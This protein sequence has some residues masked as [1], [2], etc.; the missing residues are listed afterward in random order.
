MRSPPLLFPL[1]T[2]VTLV[3]LALVPG[4]T[5]QASP[6]ARTQLLEVPAADDS[7]GP[8][9]SAGGGRL[10][11]SWIEPSGERHR[12]R[13]AELG[14]AAWSRPRDVAEGTDWFV[15]WADFPSV[16]PIADSLWAAH[17]LVSQPAGGYAY[18]VHLSFSTDAGDTWSES[19]LAHDDGTATEHGFVSLFPHSGAVGLVW[20]DGRKTAGGTHGADHAGGMTLRYAVLGPGNDAQA[21]G[22]IDGLV[23]DCCQTDAAIAASGPVVVYRNRTREEIRDIYVMRHVDGAWQEPRPVADDGWV[24]AGCPVNGPAI[25]ADGSEVA[26]A[27]FTGVGERSS[28]RLARSFD[29]G[30]TFGV[31]IE[32]AVADTPGRAG[33]ALLPG[34]GAAVSWLCERPGNDT[35]VCLRT[36]SRRGIPGPVL[37]VSGSDRVPALTVPQLASHGNALVAAWLADEG[38]TTALRSARIAH[39]Q[40]EPADRP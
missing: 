33:I 8:N 24:I 14:D 18:D 6:V 35:G 32:I 21:G 38:G 20:L 7:R 39:T 29:S 1:S 2:I 4:H 16:V 26:V 27:W 3:T 11:L 25:A 17:W 13:Y 40:L 9:L 31:P 12:L 30:A 19:V 15:N 28:V 34:G 22:E 36:V 23:C 5:P 10:V 37:E